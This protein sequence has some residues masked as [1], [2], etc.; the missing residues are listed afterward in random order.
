MSEVERLIIQVERH[1]NELR[2]WLLGLDAPLLS[3]VPHHLSARDTEVKA[4]YIARQITFALSYD[5]P[6]EKLIALP[7][8]KQYILEMVRYILTETAEPSH[9]FANLIMLA[10]TPTSVRSYLLTQIERPDL[11]HKFGS[12]ETDP[13]FHQSLERAVISLQNLSYLKRRL[14]TF[15]ELAVEEK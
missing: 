15:Q 7:D 11:Y 1:L 4:G 10:E 5:L 13:M 6:E 2:K 12:F 14:R 8:Y 9:D 3:L